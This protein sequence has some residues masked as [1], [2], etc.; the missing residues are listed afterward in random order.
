MTC[1]TRNCSPLPPPP[2]LNPPPPF[3]KP[4]PP[5]TNSAPPHPFSKII[6]SPPPLSSH[7]PIIQPPVGSKPISYS[8]IA[9]KPAVAKEIQKLA[10]PAKQQQPPQSRRPPSGNGESTSSA[11]GRAAGAA[12]TEKYRFRH[13]NPTPDPRFPAGCQLMIG[14]IPT[15]LSHDV[16]YPTV[17][18][19]LQSMGSVCFMFIHQNATKDDNGGQM[20]KYGYVVF[21][22]KWQAQ[23]ILKMGSFNLPGGRVVAVQEM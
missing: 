10:S 21:A 22:E 17:R 6:S 1:Q 8:S 20:V 13:K 18:S 23:K 2:S 12:M 3:S 15:H 5:S 14:P 11:A 7:A 9:S 16:L 19:V 4:P